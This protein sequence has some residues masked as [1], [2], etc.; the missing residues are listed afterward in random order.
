MN[1]KRFLLFIKAIFL[2]LVLEAQNLPAGFEEALQLYNNGQYTMARSRFDSLTGADASN[3]ACWYYL[4][5]CDAAAGDNNAAYAHMQ[6][7]VELDGG[8]Y[9]YRYYLA[10]ICRVLG[11]SDEMTQIYEG[12]SQDFPDKQNLEFDLLQVYLSTNQLEKALALLEDIE[13]RM[14]K[15]EET[16]RTKVEILEHLGRSDEAAAALEDYNDEFSS[17]RILSM[18]GDYYLG[19]YRDSLAIARYS[20][21]LS[22]DSLYM[23]AVLGLGESYR[24]RRNYDGYFSTMRRFTR[25]DEVPASSKALY[26]ENL[27]GQMDPRIIVMHLDGFDSMIQDAVECSPSDSTLTSAVAR[28]YYATG[29][30]RLAMES[31]RELASAYPDNIG[32][33]ATYVQFLGMQG[34]WEELRD[35]AVEAFNR[36]REMAFL[37]YANAA[38]Y[39]LK[40]YDAIIGNCQ[41][42][43]N[44]SKNQPDILKS[45]YSQMG[46]AYHSKGDNSKAYG[47]YKKALR[48]DPDYAPVLNNYA[49]YLSLE[50]KRLRK[51]ASMSHKTVL[52]EP[53]NATYLDTYGWIL[54]LQG[55]DREAKACFKHAMLYGGN[56]SAVMLDHYAQVLF[57]LG[58]YDTARATWNRAMSKNTSGEVPDLEARIR[59]A[60]QSIGR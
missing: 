44:N 31:L 5:M 11:R 30:E 7:A 9:W 56:E 46:D 23:P 40:D 29:R 43:I 38:N 59:A 57:A 25:S 53:D 32:H 49:Y 36:F 19:E 18:L 3:D 47:C 35:V 10:A 41:Y 33:V 16:V 20:E 24:I 50:N 14:G 55:K 13:T 39:Q 42:V 2:A 15:T 1:P 60:F 27:L 26:I 8:N 21:A 22:I 37:D 48:L 12:L 34:E 58:E 45:A 51:A 52:Q 17:L 28:Y 4:A 6:K 54:H